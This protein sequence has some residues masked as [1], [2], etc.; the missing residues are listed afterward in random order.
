MQHGEGLPRCFRVDGDYA[1]LRR[2][3][4]F[5]RVHAGYS[6]TLGMLDW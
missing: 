4:V 3:R 6:L 2:D 1:V 5:Q